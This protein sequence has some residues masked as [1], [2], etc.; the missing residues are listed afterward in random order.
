MLYPQTRTFRTFADA[1][2]WI[3]RVA[4]NQTKDALRKRKRQAAVVALPDEILDRKTVDGTAQQN[5]LLLGGP[6]R[7]FVLAAQRDA[8]QLVIQQGLSVSEAAARLGKTEKAV[9]KNVERGR[10][11]PPTPVSE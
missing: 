9:Q 10:A 5:E 6:G 2:Y 3:F 7:D 1:R 11:A 4:I 8:V